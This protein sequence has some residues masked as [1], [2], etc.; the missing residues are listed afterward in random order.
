MLEE[1][2]VVFEILPQPKAGRVAACRN[3]R[4]SANARSIVSAAVSVTVV[5]NTVKHPVIA[6]G[7]VAGQVVRL[8]AVEDALDGKPLPPMDEL[9]ALVSRAVRPAADLS[10]SAAFR[11]YQAGVVVA[12]ALQD[13][14][15]QKRGRR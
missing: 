8:T 7:G 2:K 14:L 5:R 1:W 11:K 13:A 12:L 4:A 15:G 6:L 9:Q 3:S 10:G